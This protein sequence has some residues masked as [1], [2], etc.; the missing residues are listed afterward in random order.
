MLSRDANAPVIVSARR[1]FRVL[2]LCDSDF[3]YFN[4]CTFT[5]VNVS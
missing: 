5:A 3:R 1:A 4:E 2:A